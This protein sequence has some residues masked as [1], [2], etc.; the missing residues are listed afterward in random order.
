MEEYNS[1]QKITSIEDYYVICTI[2]KSSEDENNIEYSMIKIKAHEKYP[3]I[4]IFE[5]HEIASRYLTQNSNPIFK[6][7]PIK[8][9]L[10][11]SKV[12]NEKISESILLLFD[13]ESI[14]EHENG[15][16]WKINNGKNIFV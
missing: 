14:I 7:L 11:K 8:N 10:L 9:L 12:Y 13:N 15:T 1:Y 4:P 5:N 6:I 2:L 3:C 16:L